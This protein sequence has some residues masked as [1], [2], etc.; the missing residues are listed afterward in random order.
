[1]SDRKQAKLPMRKRRAEIWP[2]RRKG[3]S[4]GTRPSLAS[5]AATP[6]SFRR[7]RRR[8]KGGVGTRRLPM[9]ML[10]AGWLQRRML[11]ADKERMQVHYMSQKR[12]GAENK[13][14]K[15]LRGG[16]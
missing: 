15:L 2:E 16:C 8:R 11:E 4:M 3:G 5:Q 14:F 10:E 6:G 13:P 12:G 7:W 9:R 1:M